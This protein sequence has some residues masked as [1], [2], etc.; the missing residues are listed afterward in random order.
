MTD[1]A[2][3]VLDIHVEVR[4]GI[5]FQQLQ[6]EAVLLNLDSGQYFGL[7]AVGT[8]VWSLL[9]EGK[10]LRDVVTTIVAEYEVGKE[11]CETDLAKLIGELETQ[12]LVIVS[13]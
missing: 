9:A 11:Q 6:E 8:R 1:G 4:E 10:S 3:R 12:G 7:D 5:V 13:R 2:T